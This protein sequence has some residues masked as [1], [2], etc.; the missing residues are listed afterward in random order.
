MTDLVWHGLA[1]WYVAHL[2]VWE[3]GPFNLL[4]RFRAWAGVK[5]VNGYP[6]ATGGQELSYLF[7]CVICLSFWCAVVY[8]GAAQEPW[9]HALIYGG[10]AALIEEILPE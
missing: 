6:V 1:I 3:R 10:L 4:G 9:Y 2:L 7:A 8:T 5:Q